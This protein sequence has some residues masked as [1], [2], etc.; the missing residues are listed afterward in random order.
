MRVILW[1]I[2]AIVSS[3]ANAKFLLWQNDPY[4]AYHDEQKKKQNKI[5]LHTQVQG[6]NLFRETHSFIALQGNIQI[7][8]LVMWTI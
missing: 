4:F 5:A 8:C 3:I 7:Y 2:A 1:T 6:K